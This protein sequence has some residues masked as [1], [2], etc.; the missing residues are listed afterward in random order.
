[1]LPA[2][3]RLLPVASFLAALCAVLIAPSVALAKWQRDTASGQS[4]AEKGRFTESKRLLEKALSEAQKC[5]PKEPRPANSLINLAGINQT[6][7]NYVVSEA[8]YKLVRRRARMRK[9]FHCI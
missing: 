7:G 1:M 5:G 4:L 9:Q 6:L 3:R 8:L 2:F